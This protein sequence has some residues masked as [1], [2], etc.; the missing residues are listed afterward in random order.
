[1][2]SDD[3][4]L[5]ERRRSKRAATATLPGSVPG[6]LRNSIVLPQQRLQPLL[7]LWSE[8][9]AVLGVNISKERSTATSLLVLDSKS[10]LESPC[11]TPL[12]I[13]LPNTTDMSLKERRYVHIPPM[14]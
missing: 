5:A 2:K 12:L 9:F 1:L 4:L 11:D 13:E 6:G 8:N 14:N 3:L 7:N 10:L